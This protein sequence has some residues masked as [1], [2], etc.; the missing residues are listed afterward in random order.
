MGPKGTQGGQGEA[1]GTQR[2]PRATNGRG[3]NGTHGGQ[4]EPRGAKGAFG[5]L[6]REWAHG[7]IWGYSEAISNGRQFR[8]EGY[9][10][11]KDVP[12]RKL[13]F[14]EV[15]T[16]CCEVWFQEASRRHSEGTGRPAA[17]YHDPCEFLLALSWFLKTDF[18]DGKVQKTITDTHP[19]IVEVG[20]KSTHFLTSQLSK[21][22]SIF[23]T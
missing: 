21:E 11:C 20:P 9:Y 8:M 18:S 17:T 12:K 7:A 19:Y 13:I 15:T 22:R 5:A 16:N 4:G 14:A 3:P 2:N 23:V 10:E 6:G 1:K